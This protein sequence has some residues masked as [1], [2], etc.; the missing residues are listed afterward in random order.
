MSLPKEH[1]RGGVRQASRERKFQRK[2]ATTEKV[3]QQVPASLASEAPKQT[4]V[5]KK[6]DN[7]QQFK[8]PKLQK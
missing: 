8:V 1:I 7:N 6:V 5:P 2:G 3:L 4:Q